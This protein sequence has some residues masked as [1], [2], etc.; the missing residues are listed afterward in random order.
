M[1]MMSLGLTV[2]YI[3]MMKNIKEKHTKP[4]SKEIPDTCTL[5]KIYTLWVSRMLLTCPA[6]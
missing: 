6:T 2:T 3:V 4:L 1:Q 5:I